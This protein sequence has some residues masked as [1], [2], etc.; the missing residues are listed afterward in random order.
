M[1]KY[2]EISFLVIF[3]LLVFGCSKDKTTDPVDEVTDLEALYSELFN[4]QTDED[5]DIVVADSAE[6]A[7]D[8]DLGVSDSAGIDLDGESV[9]I[10]AYDSTVSETAELAVDC[11]LLNFVFANDSTRMAMFFDCSP[12]GLVFDN[13]LIIDVGP[14][15]FNNHPTA[16]VVKLYIYDNDRNRWDLLIALPRNNPRLRFEIDHFSKYAISD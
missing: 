3:F 5:V 1:L 7:L 10:I 4:T 12:D 16:N 2:L 14:A 11:R 8:I 9:F 13:S 6:V 15:C